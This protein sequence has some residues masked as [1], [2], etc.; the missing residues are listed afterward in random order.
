MKRTMFMATGVIA[1]L[2]CLASCV[3]SPAVSTGQSPANSNPSGVIIAANKTYIRDWAGRTF[4][5]E[6]IPDWIKPATHGNFTKAKIYF[7]IDGDVFKISLGV[8]ADL[9]SAQMRATANYARIAARDLQQSIKVYLAEKRRS[10]SMTNATKQAIEGVT[11]TQSHVEI[12]GHEN[13]GEF[14][15]EVD[16]EDAVT[17]KMTRK[18]VLYQIYVIPAQTWARTTAKYLKSVLGEL[19]EDLTPDEKDVRDM[20]K[21]MMDDARHPTVMTQQEKQQELEYSRKMMDAQIKLAPEKQKAA[22]QQE[23]IK[24]S[25]EGKTE[26]TKI[27]ADA[28]TQQ[29]QALADTETTAY[30]SG[31]KA[32]Q[33]AATIT[34]ADE[35][36]LDA[37]E[38][39][40]SI[41]Y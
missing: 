13:K 17:G 32:L 30:L 24:I 3:S 41:I 25:Q 34:P 9:Q 35:N 2:V 37:M 33:A 20:V 19:P 7:D 18:V 28:K 31:N 12:T 36:W 23:L 8:G 10:G 38:T 27:A 29:T 4:G 14:W 26:R 22:A 16:V 5:A 1:L 21:T 40:L 11:Q 6:A 15:H 39:A